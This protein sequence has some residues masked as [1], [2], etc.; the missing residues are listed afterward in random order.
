MRILVVEDEK[1]M[2]ELLRNGLTESG[3]TVMTA[4]DEEAGLSLALEHEFDAMVLEVGLPGRSGYSIVEYLRR[5]PSRPAIVLLTALNK[6]DNVVRG[7]DLGA[8]DYLT[9]PYSIPELVARIA[10]AV[11]R[12]RAGSTDHF[13]FGPFYLDLGKRR[14]FCQGSEVHITRSEYLLLR[15]LAMHRGETV[16]RRQLIQAVWGATVVSHG[17]LDTL[18]NGLREKLNVQQTGL[19][20]TVP[21]AGYAL[22]EEHELKKAKAR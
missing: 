15:A 20:A 11:R 5:R 13:S 12:T 19:V 2:L 3:H 14:L 10:S 16:S 18:V 1:D 17:S 22:V 8:D 9:R 6:E 7:L 21:G 4:P